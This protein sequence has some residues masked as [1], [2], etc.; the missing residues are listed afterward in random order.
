MPALQNKTTKQV[1]G[2]RS[3]GALGPA[4]C[5]Y[6]YQMLIDHTPA[7]CDQDHIDIVISSP[8]VDTG[9]HSVIMVKQG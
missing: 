3:G 8:R 2:N 9:P 5:C 6:L 1:A 4:A 7:T